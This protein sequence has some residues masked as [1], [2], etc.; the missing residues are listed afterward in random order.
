MMMKV[1][2][3][4]KPNVF[5]ILFWKC[6]GDEFIGINCIN[7]QTVQRTNFWEWGGNTEERWIHWKIG[8]I[9]Y[10][11]I[12]ENVFLCCTTLTNNMYRRSKPRLILTG[13]VTAKWL[14]YYRLQKYQPV[15]Q[16]DYKKKD[17][18]IVQIDWQ[19]G[20]QINAGAV[21]KSRHQLPKAVLLR[22]TTC[23]WALSRKASSSPSYSSPFS[24]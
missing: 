13:E 22:C 10:K 3:I 2:M 5:C 9:T 21:T 14:R 19:I 6:C 23:L 4:H 16:I 1:K 11:Q 7:S 18:P 24:S 17:W 12:R 15:V 20:C 8:Q